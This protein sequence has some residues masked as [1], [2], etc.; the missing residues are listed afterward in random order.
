MTGS[1][2]H[3]FAIEL[4]DRLADRER[5][6]TAECSLEKA[7]AILAR[8]STLVILREAIYGTRR[9]DDFVSRTRLTEAAVATRLRDLVS[10]GLL[11]KRP[12]QEAGQRTRFE[13][14]ITRKGEELFPAVLALMEW[15]N[16][17]LQDDGIGPLQ[18]VDP[19]TGAE[20][21]VAVVPQPTQPAQQPVRVRIRVR[22]RR[23][24]AVAPPV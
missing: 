21:G 6:S 8:R 14:R 13:Y 15:G 22:R 18:F 1:T 5:W 3:P 7:A 23:D 17:Y 2:P 10:E 24:L 11:V 19:D 20:L 16:K 12:Y 4:D 9:F